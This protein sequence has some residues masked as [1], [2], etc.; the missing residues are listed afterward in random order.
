M[1]SSSAKFP[2]NGRSSHSVPAHHMRSP[3]AE[4]VLVLRAVVEKC[5]ELGLARIRCESDFAILVK[6][7]KSKSSCFY[8][9]TAVILSL[10]AFFECIFFS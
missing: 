8:R 9:I 10:A 1:E 2:Q 4:E 7:L 5:R 3:Q 6:A